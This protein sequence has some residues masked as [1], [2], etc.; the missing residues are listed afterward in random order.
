MS[1]GGKWDR[2]AKTFVLK[3]DLG[4]GIR[5]AMTALLV[6]VDAVQS[7][8]EARRRDGKVYFAMEA[9]WTRRK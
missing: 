2:D 4:T 3:Q 6:D 1:G 8:T 9:K 7:T 5:H